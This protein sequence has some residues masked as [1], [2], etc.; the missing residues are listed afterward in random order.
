M[1]MTRG[2][3]LTDIQAKRKAVRVIDIK[4]HAIMEYGGFGAKF[5]ALLTLC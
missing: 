5:H 1:T 4:N 3:R 2:Y